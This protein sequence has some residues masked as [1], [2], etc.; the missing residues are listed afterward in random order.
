MTPSDLRVFLANYPGGISLEEGETLSHC[1]EQCIS[2][3]IVEIGSFKGKS[4]VALAAGQARGRFAKDGLVYCIDPH[5]PFQ[6]LYGGV[7]GPKDRRDFYSIMLETGF[8]ERVC[9][10]NLPSV[11]ASKGW[12]QPIGLLFVDGDHT[13][14]GVSSDVAAWEPHLQVGGTLILDDALDPAAGPQQVVD[15]LLESNRFEPHAQFGKMIALRKLASTRSIPHHSRRILVACHELD[16]YGGLLRFERFGRVIVRYGHS[17]AFLV[18]SDPEKQ[19]RACEFPMLSFDQARRMSWDVTIVPGAGFPI[20]IIDRLSDLRSGCFGLRVQHVLNDQ[21]RKAAFLRVNTTFRPEIVIFNNKHWTPGTFT[22]FHANAFYFLEGAVDLEAL[23]P[24]PRRMQPRLAQAFVVGGL[25]SKNPQPLIEAVRML[26]DNVHLR[27]IG[28]HGDL[29]DRER[30]L[31]ASGRLQLMGVLRDDELPDFFAGLDCV[32]HTETFAGWAN[33]AAEGMASG[34]P[35]I[36]T[37]HGTG[38]FAQHEKTALVVPIPR[39]EALA[40]SIR[41]LRDDPELAQILAYNARRAVRGFSWNSYS[42]ELLRLMQPPTANYY[43]WSPDR[44]LFGK[45]PESERMA[46]LDA[47]L[48]GCAGKTILD[49]GAAEGVVARHLLERGA[50]LVDGFDK[51]TSR[52]RFAQRVCEGLSG[53]SFWE[54]DLSDW[55]SFEQ[56]AGHRLRD[57][58]DIVLYL[59][60]HHH[61][62]VTSRLIT[63]AE[64]AKR[65]SDL[66]VTRMP[67]EVFTADDVERVLAKIGLSVA[68]SSHSEK[69]ASALG[70]CYLFKRTK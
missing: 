7:F 63:L 41:R 42:P 60:L 4:A 31:I 24:S 48:A 13:L 57:S 65:S 69:N 53:A 67:A 27:L 8:C 49:L 51:D 45:W 22:E 37:P 32:V 34:V 36:C 43:T 2:C 15:D 19:R 38:A 23:A 6:G 47:V 21:T 66:L 70:D 39:P 1:A 52:V 68:A 30:T 50:L 59:G 33:F 40:D 10:V 11:V 3:V 54:A 64:A 25:A 62:P 9:L 55:P 26:G 44:G 46:G 18:F 5:L 14:E 61:I 29:A 28:E 12:Q 58:Y 20:E 17:L 56:A 16:V 35:V